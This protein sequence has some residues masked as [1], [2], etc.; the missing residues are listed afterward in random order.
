MFT[1]SDDRDEKV[2]LPEEDSK[3]ITDPARL[4]E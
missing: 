2:R 3:V 1:L 4:I